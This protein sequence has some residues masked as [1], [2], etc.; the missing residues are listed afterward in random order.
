MAGCITQSIGRWR[1]MRF[2]VADIDAVD[3][4]LDLIVTGLFEAASAERPIGGAYR[5]DAW[6]GS[7]LTGLRAGGIFTG[8]LGEMLTL[9]TPPAPVR[10][11]GIL[12]MGLGAGPAALC[13]HGV[14]L[15]ELA[16]RGA[17]R[18]RA[19]SVGCLLGWPERDMPQR[20]AAAVASSMMHGALVAA[21]KPEE[22]AAALDWIFHAPGREVPR[23]ADAL[24][25][26]LDART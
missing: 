6:L 13:D 11:R 2:L 18:I 15:G 22:G 24:R 17:M 25:R 7:T 10:A 23:L 19:R 14:A 20:L 1:T 9:T 8:K 26:V 12:L 5:L 4:D 3:Q 21:D 16:V